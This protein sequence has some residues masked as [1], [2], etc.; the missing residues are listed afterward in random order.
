MSNIFT[1]FKEHKDFDR[2]TPWTVIPSAFE[3]EYSVAPHYAET[4]EL[5]LTDGAKG[6]M[7]IGGRLYNLSGKQVFFIAPETVHSMH[8]L[9]SGG[10]MLNVKLSPDGFSKILNLSEM[11]MSKG[12][13]FDSITP[14]QDTY[15]ALFPLAKK[16]AAPCDVFLALTSV[17]GIFSVLSGASERDENTERVSRSALNNSE[18]REI[19]RFTNDHFSEKISIEKIAEKT[20]Y[21][22]FYFCEKFRSASGITYHSYLN[23]V[24]ISNACKLLSSG[25]SVS[26]AAEKSG[27]CDSS[28]FIRCF[29][30]IKGITPKQYIE[31]IK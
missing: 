23:G 1:A 15:D 25:A 28:Y 6:E 7:R 27:F 10:K 14:C 2:N 31:T 8:Y 21:S 12:T 17:V 24:R 26:E 29:K 5:L 30:K 19:I 22:K 3:K 11:L 16:L 9:K 20:G 13:D 4:I 18:L